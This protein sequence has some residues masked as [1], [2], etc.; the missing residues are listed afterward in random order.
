MI[1]SLE[2]NIVKYNLFKIFNKRT[3]LPVIAIYLTAVGKVTL[4]QLGI[5]ASVAAGVQLILEIPSGYFADRFGHKESLV[6][7]ALLTAVS[8]LFYLIMPNFAGGLISL[9]IFFAGA[10][11]HSGTMQAFM[12]ETM[13]GLDREKDYAKVMGRAQSYGLFGNMVL[14]ALVPLTYQISPKLPFIIGFFFMLASAVVA[15]LMVKP[16]QRIRVQEAD[17]NMFATLKKLIPKKRLLPLFII[18]TLFGFASGAF[19]QIGLY[20]DILLTA[21][22]IPVKY[23]GFVLAGGSLLAAIVGYH[24]HK[25]KNWPAMRFYLFDITYVSVAFILVG[26]AVHPAFT[27]FALMLFP[28]YDRSRNVIYESRLLEEFP[29]SHHKST[30]LSIMNFF[31]LAA[32]IVIP[33]IIVYMVSSTDLFTGHMWFGVSTGIFLVIILLFYRV[34]VRTSS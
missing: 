27:I 12:Y 11:F 8:V 20:R 15:Y 4:A 23:L 19:D 24:I 31:N 14:V 26:I 16:P 2:G 5:M 18:F 6:F 22:G 21:S 29:N 7:G 13:I 30:L 1:A 34:C 10:A 17:S 32:N 3:F 9:A 25:L 33:F 28:A